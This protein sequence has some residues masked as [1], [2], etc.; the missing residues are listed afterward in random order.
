MKKIKKIS[1][2]LCTII[3]IGSLCILPCFAAEPSDG[4]SPAGMYTFRNNVDFSMVDFSSSDTINIPI[5]IVSVNPVGN[6]E[7][8][9]VLR[10][11]QN[12]VSQY[13]TV[14]LM[15][16]VNDEVF[17]PIYHS[18][19]GWNDSY[20]KYQTFEVASEFDIPSVVDGFFDENLIIVPS[21]VPSSDP[22][23]LFDSCY[24]L[25]VEYVFA[26]EGVVDGVLSDPAQHLVVTIVSTIAY[27]FVI[28]LPFLVVWW[29]IKVITTAFGRF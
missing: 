23:N 13:T 1:C 7:S 6:S 29:V 11:Y 16:F 28:I 25:I 24:D 8:Y 27:L 21:S 10:L 2:L 4:S 20:S 18:N 19:T 26:G 12:V 5:N 22:I 15:Y 9:N 3:L 17:V 14:Y